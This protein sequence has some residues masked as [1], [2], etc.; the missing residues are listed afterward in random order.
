MNQ[1]PSANQLTQFVS[2]DLTSDNWDFPCQAAARSYH[3]Q[4]SRQ[5]RWSTAVGFLSELGPNRK[6]SM[7]TEAGL[8]ADRLTAQHTGTYLA[9][10]RISRV[11]QLTFSTL[12]TFR[13]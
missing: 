5:T 6:G 3:L 1:K 11:S 9:H 8:L 10:H 2:R 13:L 7:W 12:P 4:S